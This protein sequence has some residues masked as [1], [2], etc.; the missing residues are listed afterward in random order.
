MID[1]SKKTECTLNISVKVCIDGDATGLVPENI[2]KMLQHHFRCW[3]DGRYPFDVELIHH[4]LISSLKHAKRD[5]LHEHFENVHGRVMVKTGPGSSSSAASLSA[6]EFGPKSY[7][8]L[9]DELS[10]S[11]S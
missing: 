4:G 2:A 9:V 11:V 5:C 10:V 1:Y 7:I 6:E 3:N 8:R